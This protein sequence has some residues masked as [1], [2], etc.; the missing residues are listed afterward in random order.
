[1]KTQLLE[2]LSRVCNI[3]CGRIDSR[4]VD[5]VADSGPFCVVFKSLTAILQ[6]CTNKVSFFCSDFMDTV[7]CVGQVYYNWI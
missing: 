3:L 5:C 4:E 1:M 7:V 2:V 6:C